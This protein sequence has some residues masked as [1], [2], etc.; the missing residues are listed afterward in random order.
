MPKRLLPGIEANEKPGAKPDAPLTEPVF[1]VLLSLAQSPRHGY[2]L[3]KDTESLSDGRVKLSTGTLYGVI[4]RLLQSGWIERFETEDKS[5]EKQSYRLTSAGR[6]FLQVEL[7]R[8]K[9]LTRVAAVRLKTREA[10]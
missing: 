7:D 3:L 5:R 6:R 1:L 9:Q 10:Q 8:M 4:H 2:A